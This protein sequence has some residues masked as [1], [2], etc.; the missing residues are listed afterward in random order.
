[1]WDIKIA[2]RIWHEDL[3]FQVMYCPLMRLERCVKELQSYRV[4]H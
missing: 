3:N 2:T 4:Y 1:M